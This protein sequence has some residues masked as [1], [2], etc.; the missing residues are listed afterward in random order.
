M[1]ETSVRACGA[2][3]MVGAITWAVTW[4]VAGPPEEGVNQ[5]VEI[6]GSFAY[7]LGLVALLAAMRATDA[8]G[9][10]RWGRAVVTG[11]AVLV[12]LAIAWTLPHLAD[13]NYMS[14]HDS[15]LLVVLDAAWPLSMLG[16]VAVGVAV[17]RAGRWTGALRWLP[18]A[19]S[20]LLPVDVV[21]MVL[22]GPELEIVV[23]A[24]WMAV[25]YGLLGGLLL[26][27]GVPVASAPAHAHPTAAR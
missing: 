26:R 19:A 6:W 11:E 24:A 15:V 21:A 9:P 16:L 22:L 8:T 27:G 1:R 2:A 17:A 3:V 7:Q 4:L 5:S 23:R 25:T 10:S 18:L 20:L 12:A 14:K 13:P